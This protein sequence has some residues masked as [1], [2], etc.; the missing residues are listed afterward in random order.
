MKNLDIQKPLLGDIINSFN[1]NTV[2]ENLTELNFRSGN[3]HI[4]LTF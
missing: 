1:V 3:K 2:R 4:F